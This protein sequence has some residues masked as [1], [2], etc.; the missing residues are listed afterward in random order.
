MTTQFLPQLTL[1]NVDDESRIFVGVK[2]QHVAERTVGQ[3]RTEDGD[4]I[5]CGP[6][7]N[8]TL[9]IDLQPK[10]SDDFWRCPQRTLEDEKKIKKY[11]WLP[12]SPVVEN[13]FFLKLQSI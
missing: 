1:Q 8:R 6:V 9:V 5:F 7:V 10:T 2:E 12:K 4:L 11:I 13:L 3:G